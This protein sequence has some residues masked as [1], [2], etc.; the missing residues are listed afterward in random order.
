MTAL[1]HE[2]PARQPGWS[3]EVRAMPV[4]TTENALFDCALVYLTGRRDPGMDRLALARLRKYLER[5]GFLW[6]DDG[7][8]PGNEAFGRASRRLLAKIMPG[9]SLRRVRLTH[10][11]FSSAYELARGYLGRSVPAGAWA[12]QSE[13]QGLFDPNGRLVAVHTRNGYG[14]A[15]ELDPAKEPSFRPPVGLTP[16]E[17]R[18]GALRMATN[19]AVHVLRSGGEPLPGDPA[20]EEFDPARRYRYRGRAIEA[21]RGA[22]DHAAWRAV[23]P[24]APVG[25][26]GRNETLV[27]DVSPSERDTAG[28]ARKAIGGIERARAVVFDVRL[29]R[30]S[31][32]RVALR[33]RSSGGD[34]YESTPL[35]IRAGL[36][37]DLRV[38][39]DAAD[40]RATATGFRNYD[41]PLDTTKA[42]ASLAVIL[43]GKDL[44]GRV[45]FS[46][47][48]LEGWGAR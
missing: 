36:N 30:S 1:A 35:Y 48:R 6:I 16:R 40:F 43:Y 12:R 11:L 47:L 28:A 44:G 2:L 10:P 31:P 4:R 9:A 19:I 3:F 45:E 23:K 7:A 14:R 37:A 38:P 32:A 39:L 15:M 33:F 21:V 29:G 8:P 34:V 42:M 41:A 26:S 22:F 13:V 5:G 18:E 17:A 27:L 46:R 20:R 24:G 25:V